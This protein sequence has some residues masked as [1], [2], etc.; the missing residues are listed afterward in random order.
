MGNSH[1]IWDA[2]KQIQLAWS[3][4]RTIVPLVGAGISAD[5]GIP[6]VRSIVRYF[7]KFHQMIEHGAYFD[8]DN[9]PEGGGS[10]AVEA[11][12][13]HYRSFPWDFV[14]DFG[15][16]DRFKLNQD[17]LNF[18]HEQHSPDTAVS[19]KRPN[20]PESVVDAARR[21]IDETLKHINPN[22]VWGIDALVRD[23]AIK[24]I[25]L[26]YEGDCRDRVINA[27]NAYLAKPSDKQVRGG[28]TNNTSA[29]RE[30]LINLDP[31]TLRP[32]DRND[33]IGQ[34]ERDTRRAK[35]AEASMEIL[36]RFEEQSG[37]S[38][39]F[40]I[41][42]DWKRLIQHFTKYQGDLADSLISRFSA[43]RGPSLG[44]QFLAYLCRLVGSKL[45]MTYN[46]DDLIE[47]SL[48]AQGISPRIF[49]LEEGIRLPP[50]TLAQDYVSVFKLHGN[51]HA[52][53]LDERV[54]HP[55]SDLYKD[56][57]DQLVGENPLLLVVGCSGGDMRVR[58]LFRHV[59]SKN[60]RKCAAIWMYF[61]NEPPACVTDLHKS[62][63]A[64]R[65][66]SPG[67]DLMHIYTALSGRHPA[68]GMSPYTVNPARPSPIPG[69]K[70]G[71]GQRA[72]GEP[73]IGVKSEVWK[74]LIVPERTAVILSALKGKHEADEDKNRVPEFTASQELLRVTDYW[75]RDGYQIIWVDLESVHT[76]SGIVG[77]ILDQC[78]AYDIHLAPSVLPKESDNVVD[79][80]VRRV[81]HA[82]QRSRY[83]VVLDAL[84]SYSWGPLTHHGSTHQ[85]GRT[86]AD[87]TKLLAEFMEFFY[88]LSK[89]QALG[90]SRVWLGVD[91]PK[92]RN[93]EDAAPTREEL[94]HLIT[95][96]DSLAEFRKQ[97][98]CKEPELLGTDWQ[99][100]GVLSESSE[101][102]L[103]HLYVSKQLHSL[104]VDALPEKIKAHEHSKHFWT[105]VLHYLACFR[106]TRNLA[107]LRHVLAVLYGKS[108]AT[109][110]V[111]EL[112][113]AMT[114]VEGLGI[115]RLSGGG[116]WFD[117]ATRDYIYSRN[118]K[119]GSTDDFAKFLKGDH[120]E[121]RKP[122]NVLFQLFLLTTTHQQISRSYYNRAFCQSR[123]CFAFLEYTYHRVSSIRYLAKLIAAVVR[124]GNDRLPEV[125]DALKKCGEFLEG[126]VAG[127]VNRDAFGNLLDRM[128]LSSPEDGK[129]GIDWKLLLLGKSTPTH[130]EIMSE[131]LNRH[132]WEIRC[133]YRGWVRAE[134]EL[135]T[136][137]PAQQLLMWCERLIQEELDHRLNSVVV[138][139]KDGKPLCWNFADISAEPISPRAGA[140][141]DGR[142]IANNGAV[143]WIDAFRSFLIDFQIKLEV[144]RTDYTAAKRLVDTRPA[145]KSPLK[146]FHSKLDCAI[147]DL[148]EEHQKSDT[149]ARFSSKWE[150]LGKDLEKH[151]TE[152]AKFGRYIE[153]LEANGGKLLNNCMDE[154][155]KP[156]FEN[157]RLH[158]LASAVTD[159]HEANLRLEHIRSD[160]QLVNSSVFAGGFSLRSLPYPQGGPRNICEGFAEDKGLVR[161][162]DLAKNSINQGYKL[163]RPQVAYGG[164]TPQSTLIER[165]V[166]GSVYPAYRSV[167]FTLRGRWDWQSEAADGN[168]L[169]RSGSTADATFEAAYRDFEMARGG[170]GTEN[171]LLLA[172]NEL[173]F[174]EASLVHARVHQD[175]E[176]GK[177]ILAETAHEAAKYALQRARDHLLA[178]R[179]NVV[180]WKFYYQ[181]TAQYHAER[182][183]LD[184]AKLKKIDSSKLPGQLTRLR[185]GYNAIRTGLDYTLPNSDK[186]IRS[187]WLARAWVEMTLAAYVLG[188]EHLKAQAQRSKEEG[189][190]TVLDLSQVSKYVE[191]QIK[192]LNLR[193]GLM[194]QTG[195]GT[196]FDESKVDL[197]SAI[198]SI[199]SLAD[200]LKVAQGPDR[201]RAWSLLFAKKLL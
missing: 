174:A 144:D 73:P 17:L 180:W 90:E 126:A 157:C 72:H 196:F 107:T 7:G 120:N 36:H 178:G 181:M 169:L 89:E 187:H 136:Q 109:V 175:R 190:R 62:A 83:F 172:I 67:A 100:L 91:V 47:R 123:D 138:D 43:G 37:S 41:S 139:Y 25:S 44:H 197:R 161:R 52:L 177:P 117:R 195:F 150:S 28:H 27:V 74:Q 53:L 104:L 66:N 140:E 31:L 168:F 125:Y 101:N 162:L 160:Y 132:L 135:R 96:N 102:P 65:T 11:R 166:D 145:A 201:I 71:G 186:H 118:S 20:V 79:L 75:L 1:T 6:V 182:L 121:N 5:S 192:W 185:R 93:S 88:K 32:K 163:Y 59:A 76:L 103:Q 33:I 80:A 200:D 156:P 55:L 142:V 92:A 116:V 70:V 56:R 81:T 184:L 130:K 110:K 3:E 152:L 111:D 173:Y 95:A 128:E 189:D 149:E 77:S 134:L 94:L 42:G 183:T 35:A 188:I 21:G 171:R 60:D 143:P 45:I 49:G 114:N 22:A 167:F 194:E 2:Y 86:H 4:G 68:A 64:V 199:T 191:S 57:F 38:V 146:A 51:N 119:Y 106:R 10:D 48:I 34:K 14:H 99:P 85:F 58:D 40:N 29:L 18:I 113:R 9:W 131:L 133:L 16:P 46:F 158:E 23:V 165:S 8:K 61:E 12:L 198:D 148:R 155:R 108:S 122:S 124:L 127:S 30:A 159:W 154:I 63:L 78:R 129:D 82:L 84:E 147:C 98:T 15:W 179:R 193:E 50:K 26:L 69:T 153:E 141:M 151:A 87:V 115:T 164:R 112:L 97:S 137:V 54:D 176:P 19:R 24:S 39:P 105:F 13:A 170:L